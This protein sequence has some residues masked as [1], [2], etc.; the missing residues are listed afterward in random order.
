MMWPGI[1]TVDDP[2][3]DVTEGSERREVEPVGV[4]QN[5]DH[6]IED[7]F[8]LH[9]EHVSF[10]VQVLTTTNADWFVFSTID[11]LCLRRRNELLFTFLVAVVDCS[12]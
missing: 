2:L 8:A 12:D 9:K 11:R 5:H 4:V 3:T 6:V 10:D 7:G 1:R